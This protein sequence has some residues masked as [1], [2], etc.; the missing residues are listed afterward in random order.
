MKI[1]YNA[2]TGTVIYKSKKSPLRSKGSRKNFQVFSATDFIA[3]IT[4]HIPEKS[5]QLMRD[6]SW[7]SNQDRGEREKRKSA[8]TATL[9]VVTARVG[10]IDVSE[11]RPKK[12]VGMRN[13]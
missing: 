9:P 10:I 11:Y 13:Y 1:R 3:A 6:Y 7:Y 5:F 12:I 2:A 8:V 4:Q